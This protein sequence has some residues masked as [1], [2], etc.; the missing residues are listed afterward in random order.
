M[1]C[2]MYAKKGFIVT[3]ILIDP[4]FKYLEKLLNRSGQHIGYVAPNGNPVEPL[5]NVTGKNRH[6]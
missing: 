3:A 2:S 4:E 6:A 5:I 1:M